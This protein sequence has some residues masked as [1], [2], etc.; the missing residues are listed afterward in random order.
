MMTDLSNLV[1]TAVRAVEV[2]NVPFSAGLVTPWDPS[3]RIYNRD[4]VA[5]R[6]ETNAGLWAVALDGEYSPTLPATAHA[7]QEWVGPYLVG[8]PVA[9]MEAH[10]EMLEKLRPRGRFFF[11]GGALWDLLGQAAGLPLYRLWGGKRDKVRVYASTVHHGKSPAERAEDCLAYLGRGYRAVKLRLSGQTVADDVAL[12]TACRHAVGDR[13]AILVDANQ[14][15]KVPGRAN[16]GITWDLARALETAEE[17]ARL[18]VGYLEEPLAY[19]LTEEG[20]MLRQKARLPIA[21]GEGKAGLAAY[22][23]L[24]QHGMYDII[25]P[26]P[27]TSGTPGTVYKIAAMAEGAGLAVIYHHGKSGYGFM[28]GLHLSTSLGEAPWLEY[29][30]DTEYWQPRGF[31]VGFEQVIPVDSEGCVHCPSEAGLGIRWDLAWL[32]AV[33]LD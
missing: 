24:M 22:W 18:G 31:Q 14:A 1:V 30:D 2:R 8:K 17:L 26:D 11:I 25:Q 4:Y 3:Q 6:I 15:G 33:G 21:G 20:A 5:V 16:P 27:I 32:R 29:M 19:A 7:V 28:I 23:Q 13:M 12:V 9:D 10:T